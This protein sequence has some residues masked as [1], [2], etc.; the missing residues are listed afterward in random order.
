MG[1]LGRTADGNLAM[2][3]NGLLVN[4]CACCQGF[5]NCNCTSGDTAP[6]IGLTVTW[7]ENEWQASTAYYVSTIVKYTPDPSN[8]P[9]TYYLFIKQNTGQHTSGASAPSWDTTVG[10]TTTDNTI[11]WVRIP[12]SCI[13]RIK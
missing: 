2:T 11:T 6:R 10:N 13:S 9:D 3:A 1:N 5:T 4:D 12:N 7:T 8:D